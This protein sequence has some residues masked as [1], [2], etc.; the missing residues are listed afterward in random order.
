MNGGVRYTGHNYGDTLNLLRFPDTTVFDIGA[1]YVLPVYGK[2]LTLR[3]TIQNLFDRDYWVVSQAHV[4]AAPPR[5]FM[6]N[7]QVDF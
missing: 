3:G 4:S 1:S 7:A 5:T 2:Q 6:V